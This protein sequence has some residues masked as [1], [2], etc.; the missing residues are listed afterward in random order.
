MNNI[1]VVDILGYIAACFSTFAMLPQAIHIYKTNEVEQLSLR[2]FTMAT[3][4]AVLWL[5]YGLLI[6][7]MV[8]ILA[9]AI[10]IL[11]VGYIFTKKFIHHR[12]QHDSTF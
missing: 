11:I 5:V 12:K 1:T 4:G 6:N 2:T 10:G 3:I 9:N 7:N 8:V